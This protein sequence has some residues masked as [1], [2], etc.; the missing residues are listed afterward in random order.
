MNCVIVTITHGQCTYKRLLYSKPPH[1]E[2]KWNLILIL[3]SKI[4]QQEVGAAKVRV[5]F[6]WEYLII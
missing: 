2:L 4:S 5:Y 6:W 3:A 1:L